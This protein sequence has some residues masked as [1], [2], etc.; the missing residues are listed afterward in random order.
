MCRTSS[1]QLTQY[2]LSRSFTGEEGNT[3]VGSQLEGE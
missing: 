3:V 2:Q 1:V